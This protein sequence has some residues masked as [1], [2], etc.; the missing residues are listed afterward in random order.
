M[1]KDKDN[2]KTLNSKLNIFLILFAYIITMAGVLLGA[3][4]AE[5]ETI[6]VGDISPRRYVATKNVENKIETQRLRQ[7][8][9]DSVGNLY[10]L[11]EQVSVDAVDRIDEM[12][13]AVDE[14]IAHMKK[15]AQDKAERINKINKL[16]AQEGEEY[17]IVEPEYNYNLK[18]TLSVPVYVSSYHYIDYDNLDDYEKIQYKE[19][20]KS[21]VSYAFEQGI[22][23]DT[24]ENNVR[25]AEELIDT[26]VYSDYLKSLAKSVTKAVVVPNLVIDEEAIAQAKEL[27][28]AAVEPVIIVKNQKI[29]DSGEMVTEEI[30]A[31]LT[32]LNLI[33]NGTD[34][35]TVHMI[36][37][38][39]ITTFCF[40]AAIMY[41]YIMQKKILRKD[42][43]G[44]LLFFIYLLSVAIFI[45]TEG[46][47]SFAF[48]P[49][50]IFG[51]LVSILISPK[52][53]VCLNTFVC[54]IGSFIFTGDIYCLIYFLISGSFSAILIEHTQRRKMVLVI[55]LVIGII[56]MLAYLGISIFA[57]GYTQSILKESLYACG[58]GIVSLVM[59]IGSL[60]LWEGIFGINTKI[61][62]AELANPNN[63]LM[64]RLIIEIPGTYHHSLVVSNLA[65]T[66][67]YEIHAN[68]TLAKVG[69]LLHDLGKLDNPQCFSENQ[70]GTNV[71][72]KMD[73]FISAKTIIKHVEDGVEYA[74]KHKIPKVVRD[75]IQEHHG[76]SLVKYFYVQSVNLYEPAG[77]AVNE[78]DYRYAGPI[79]QSKESAIVMLAD[80]VEA[81]VRSYISSGKDSAD[82]EKLVD[83]LVK[84]KLDDGQLD[85]CRLDLKEIDIIKKVFVQMLGGMYHQRVAYPKKEEIEAARAKSAEA[86]EGN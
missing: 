53:A 21:A 56:N 18:L 47:N 14:G 62:L 31:V 61:T 41:M 23:E 69:G 34:S 83:I 67:A 86:K 55:S 43:T 71:H 15:A 68:E 48:V 9:M 85:D 8:A 26:F 20:I 44:I 60:P 35:A 24:K 17:E 81:A 33:N 25:K 6:N 22:T 27:R 50:G 40:I 51:M 82:I 78:S 39:I 16:S 11:D 45:F 19:S 75:I 59:V 73:P 10:K 79:P 13:I 4:S 63:S 52:L 64:R 37:S 1:K 70:L 84:D 28:A 2:K 77:E 42:N 7:E 38:I 80:T 46:V 49:V 3:F 72:D 74:K 29:V 58:V 66:A 36:G 32:E 12:F 76:T 30:H 54:I 57:A 5:N 65:E